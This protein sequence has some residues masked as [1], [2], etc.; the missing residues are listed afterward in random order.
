MVKKTIGKVN[1]LT[2]SNIPDQSSTDDDILVK[3][4]MITN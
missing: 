1:P 4:K 2:K 3:K